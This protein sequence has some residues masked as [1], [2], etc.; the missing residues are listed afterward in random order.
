[1]ELRSLRY[2]VTVAEELNFG[3]AAKRLYITQPGLSQGIKALERRIGVPLFE[4][5]RQQVMLT[6]A[7]Q[8]LL[9]VVL[10]LLAHARE[11]DEL[12]K[13]LATTVEEHVV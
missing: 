8:E 3:R 11:L 7:G 1:M 12:A 13:H 5:S 10:D 4:R 9:P 2:F 6:R